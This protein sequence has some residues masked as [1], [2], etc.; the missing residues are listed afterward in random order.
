MRKQ[1]K[2]LS[3]FILIPLSKWYL[4]K[5]R[6]FTFDGVSIIV[7]QGVFHPGLFSSTKI[8]LNFLKQQ[9]L[10]G[11]TLLELGCG[12]ALISVWASAKAKAIVTASDISTL[13]TAN[14]QINAS[15]NAVELEIIHSDLFQEIKPKLFDWIVI[16]PPYYAQTPRNEAE[17]AWYCGANFEYFKMLFMQLPQY[18]NHNSN[19]LMVLTKGCDLK[20]ITKIASTFHYALIVLKEKDVLFDEKDYLFQIIR[21]D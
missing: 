11:K 3:S 5:D 4:R 10:T 16:N 15:T 7:K 1:F 21:K 20:A 12:T 13:A 8:L 9:N 17:F 19:V 2:Y 18:S 6:K 14:A